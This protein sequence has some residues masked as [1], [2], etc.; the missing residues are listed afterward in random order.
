LIG[1]QKLAA[2]YLNEQR[3]NP[4]NITTS[5][6]NAKLAG[7]LVAGAL[8]VSAQSWQKI[9]DLPEPNG[10][11][12]CGEAGG[13]VVYMGGTN[14][15]TGATK[16]WLRTVHQLN[17]T[18]LR[19]S[20]VGSLEQPY[21]YG[22]GG[23]ID[24]IFVAIGGSTGRAPFPGVIRVQ[25]GKLSSHPTAGLSVPAV[26]SSGGLIGDEIVIVGGTHDAAKVEALNG[27]AYAWNA[28]T[29]ALR[30]LPAYPGP[31]LGTGGATVAG[32][33]LFI[34]AGA[35]WDAASQTLVNHADS[36]A[37]SPS[38]NA[39][40]K[41]RAFP[42]EIRMV[43]AVALDDRYIYLVG[44]YRNDEFVD[45][46]YRYDITEDRYTPA[47]ALPFRAG[48]HGVKCG[49]YVYC[50]GG[51]DRAKHRSVDAYRIK[52]AELLR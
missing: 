15:E 50:F 23:T 32:D 21:A 7:I 41:L 8:T 18:T 30:N 51:E 28:R 22:V 5:V 9:A 38:R 31:N 36:Y 11:L 1:I 19:W 49:E 26:L 45:Q 29:G 40:R 3:I 27:N 14:W 4:M 39:W 2:N 13:K 42:V 48:T 52:V 35:H 16:N 10:G 24:G 47:P 12:V 17:P 44:G 25:E 34:F 46:G 43:A 37:F 6:K 20:T 33:E